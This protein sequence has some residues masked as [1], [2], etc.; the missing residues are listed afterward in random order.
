MHDTAL[1]L[2]TVSMRNHP[3]YETVLGSLELIEIRLF[4]NTA[5]HKFEKEFEAL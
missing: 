4:T 1:K 3:Q 2:P 5:R